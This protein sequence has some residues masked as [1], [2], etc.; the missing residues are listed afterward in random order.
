[1]LAQ[2]ANAQT[3][4]STP[5]IGYY[6]FDVPAGA[7][8]WASGFV[9]KK[10]F[11]G[12]A[13]AV[14]GAPAAGTITLTQTGA[15]WT[16]NQFNTTGVP[17]SSSHYV[18][19]LSDGNATH[20][21]LIL[22]IVSNT[23][24]TVTVEVPAGF[25]VGG[26]APTYAIR[27]H[28]TLNTVLPNGAG[29]APNED[30]VIIIDSVGN[31]MNAVYDGAG[32]WFDIATSA[33][34]TNTVIYPGQGFVI[35]A[36]APRVCTIG[37][38]ENSYVKDGPTKISI[39]GGIPNLVGGLNPLV[40]TQPA[41]PIYNTLA[42]NTTIANGINTIAPNSDLV[43]KPTLDGIFDTQYNYIF[44]GVHVTDIANPALNL[45]TDTIRNGTALIFV[46]DSDKS[47]TIPQT[48]P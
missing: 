21:G 29:L 17:T 20:A 37:G 27:K 9:T 4:S 32:G 11:Q 14:P 41:D 7:S 40:A 44:D 30:I 42:V 39:Y 8:G 35:L 16:A 47:F 12:Q 18:E 38:N 6:K 3:S 24:T 33:N 13:S 2:V 22:D 25:V 5:I 46:P 48:H 28:A 1:M 23:A 26:T 15:T 10:E 43:I 36:N 34:L 31:E 45:D 19:I